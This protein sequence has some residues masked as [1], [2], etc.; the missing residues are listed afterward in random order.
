[1]KPHKNKDPAYLDYIREACALIISRTE[2]L[3]L[4]DFITNQGLQDGIAMRLVVIGESSTKLT[5]TTRRKYPNVM[6]RDM[7]SLR[8]IIVH[9]YGHIDPLKI[10]DIVK[11]HIP[12]LLE[13]LQT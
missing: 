4:P 1:M 12:K 11:N 3:R 5:E 13:I 10:W 6:W 8:N 7:T 2:H 9:D